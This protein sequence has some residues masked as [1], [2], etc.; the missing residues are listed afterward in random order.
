MVGS[1]TH[2]VEWCVLK[3]GINIARAPNTVSRQKRDDL[4]RRKLACILESGKDG[5][6]VVGRLGDQSVNG[7]SS[8]VFTTSKKLQLGCTLPS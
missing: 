8:R 3:S 7:G 4:K 2:R 1:I 6:N 5:R